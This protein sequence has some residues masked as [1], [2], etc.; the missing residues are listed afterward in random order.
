MKAAKRV[1]VAIYDVGTPAARTLVYKI[2]LK[3][4][5]DFEFPLLSVIPL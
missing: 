5:Y 1:V 4:T 2:P 3:R